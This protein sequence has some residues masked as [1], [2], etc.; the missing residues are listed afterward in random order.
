MPR[1]P[2]PARTRVRRAVGAATAVLL[3]AGGVAACGKAGPED[4]LNDF[5]AGGRSGDLNKVGFVSADGSK[6]AAKDVVDQLRSLSGDLAKSPLVLS[7]EG[8]PKVTGEIASSS[9]KLDWTLPSGAPWS[10]KTTVRMT[11]R[12]SDGWRVVWEPAIVNSELTTGDKLKL[13]R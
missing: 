4:T 7:A 6:I 2:R 11:E 8:D 5:L 9:V 12:G 1:S 3:L 13:R 10:Y